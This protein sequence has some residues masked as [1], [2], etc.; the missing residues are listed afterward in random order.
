MPVTKSG[1]A[2]FQRDV[3]VFVPILVGRKGGGGGGG[4]WDVA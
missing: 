3:E 4:K 1:S 2:E